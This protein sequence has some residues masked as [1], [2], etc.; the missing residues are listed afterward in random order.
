M[1]R[2][3]QHEQGRPADAAERLRAA[4]AQVEYDDRIEARRALL[5]EQLDWLA[6]RRRRET[7][8][9]HGSP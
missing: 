1:G 2:F 8:R 7:E 3:E 9:E 4:I 5:Y 6:A